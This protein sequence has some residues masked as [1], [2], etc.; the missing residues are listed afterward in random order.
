MLTPDERSFQQEEAQWD[1][2]EGSYQAIQGTRPQTLAFALADSPIGCASW[3]V[4]KFRNWSDCGG[5][6][7]S[8]FPAD[9]LIDNIM[10]YW[11]TG[12]IGSSI[13]YYRDV[14]IHRAPATWGSRVLV[15]TPFV[16]GP[17]ELSSPPREWAERLYAV[18]SFNRVERG[19]HFL[20]WEDPENTAD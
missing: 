7:F 16:F 14:R 13:R 17:H 2:T 10:N 19:G 4:E 18:R 8:V 6:V 9:M 20:A 12:T 1:A 5:D 11:M 3:I 15:P